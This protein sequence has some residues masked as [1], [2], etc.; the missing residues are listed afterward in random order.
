MILGIIILILISAL[1]SLATVTWL[2]CDNKVEAM[3][4]TIVVILLCILIC[5]I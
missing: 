3:F 2:K 1:I 4:N 5:N